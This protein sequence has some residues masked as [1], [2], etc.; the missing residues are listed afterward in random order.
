MTTR[1]PDPSEL[2]ED[3]ARIERAIERGATE[4][5]QAI[6]QLSTRIEER[7]VTKEAFQGYSALVE[8][9]IG[10][11]GLGGKVR[12]MED[13]NVWLVR[14]VVGSLVLPLLVIVLAALFVNG[15]PQ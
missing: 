5:R 9:R 3:L 4:T 6:E 10:D 2:A 12:K 8:Q 15:G 14:A 1:V 11:E 13:R 7:Y